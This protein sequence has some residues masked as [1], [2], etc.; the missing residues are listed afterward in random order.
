MIGESEYPKTKIL[1]QRR[2][3]LKVICGDLSATD[4]ISVFF[5]VSGMIYITFILSEKDVLNAVGRLKSS[6]KL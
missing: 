4:N 2:K 6:I 3:R 5:S 1:E